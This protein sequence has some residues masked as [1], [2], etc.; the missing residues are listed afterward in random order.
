MFVIWG[1]AKLFYSHTGE[2]CAVKNEA[3]LFAFHMEQVIKCIKWKKQGTE[4]VLHY[5][6]G[7]CV[8][9]HMCTCALIHMHIY[10]CI[11]RLSLEWYIHT[12]THKKCVNVVFFG[13]RHL[14]DFPLNSLLY[15][16][17]F[18]SW[19]YILFIK[20]ICFLK[21]HKIVI[22]DILRSTYHTKNILEIVIVNFGLKRE[23]MLEENCVCVRC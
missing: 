13:G 18:M 6:C 14:S 1:L 2:Y 12:H 20:K 4:L 3:A 7:S 23:W 19:V 5:H 16:L 21:I 22:V 17:N 15:L 10:V 9:V 8:Y 11:R